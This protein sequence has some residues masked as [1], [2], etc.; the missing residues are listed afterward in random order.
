MWEHPLTDEWE[1]E[2]RFSEVFEDYKGA[3]QPF[4]LLNNYNADDFTI[5]TYEYAVATVE[6]QHAV[7]GE[8]SFS[9]LAEAQAIDAM[10]AKGMTNSEIINAMKEQL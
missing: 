3:L 6:K 2:L 4:Q 7:F 5:V 10:R 8:P 9:N 1:G